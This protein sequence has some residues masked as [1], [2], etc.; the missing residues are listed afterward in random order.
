MMKTSVTNITNC[1]SWSLITSPSSG[2]TYFDLATM[3]WL[4]RQLWK[5]RNN[6]VFNQLEPNPKSVIVTTKDAVFE[7]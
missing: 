2:F 1:G 7:Y 6:K 5:A 3:C 4:L